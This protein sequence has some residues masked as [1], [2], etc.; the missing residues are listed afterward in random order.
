MVGK[1]DPGKKEDKKALLHLSWG[2]AHIT[3]AEL[4]E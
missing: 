3:G 4:S 2:D 1:T